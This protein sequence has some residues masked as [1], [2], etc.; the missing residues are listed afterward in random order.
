[1]V[2]GPNI[3][4][5]IEGQQIMDLLRRRAVG[6][7]FSIVRLHSFEIPSLVSQ[8]LPAIDSDFGRICHESDVDGSGAAQGS[9]ARVCNCA[10]IETVL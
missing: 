8:L 3:V 7:E 6:V 4:H 1:M 5:V 9:S 10:F 2:C